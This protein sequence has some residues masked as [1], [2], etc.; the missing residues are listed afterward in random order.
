MADFYERLGHGSP[1][2][3]ALSAARHRLRTMS[4]AQALEHCERERRRTDDPDAEHSLSHDIARLRLRAGDVTGALAEIDARLA[5]ASAGSPHQHRML[6]LRNR[7]RYAS[8]RHD[9]HLPAFDHPYYWAPFT[10]VGD[11]R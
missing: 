6:M 7:A 8:P 9:H 11:W 3:T 1:L 10:L 4:L 2:A 5:G